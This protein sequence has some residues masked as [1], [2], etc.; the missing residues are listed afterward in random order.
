M[1]RKSRSSVDYLEMQTE[2]IF[3]QLSLEVKHTPRDVNKT[4]IWRSSEVTKG[5][6]KPPRCAS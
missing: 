1:S 3:N 2:V 6:G 4:A 5:L